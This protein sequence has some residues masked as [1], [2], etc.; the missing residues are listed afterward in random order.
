MSGADLGSVAPIPDSQFRISNFPRRFFPWIR[1]CMCVYMVSLAR[2]SQV[3]FI[4]KLEDAQI[5]TRYNAFS[6]NN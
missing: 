4:K 3:D 2:A 1:I 6:L 5:Y